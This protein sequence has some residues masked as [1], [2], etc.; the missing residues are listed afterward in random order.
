M[1]GEWRNRTT[2][3]RKVIWGG[4]EGRRGGEEERGGREEEGRR[5]GEVRYLGIREYQSIYKDVLRV[6]KSMQMC[7]TVCN[8]YT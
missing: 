2:A 8:D 4:E 3:R 7:T 6:C 1:G 5:R